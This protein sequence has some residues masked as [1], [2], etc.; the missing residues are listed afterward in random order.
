MPAQYVQL[1][2]EW[3]NS[4]T[5]SQ[6][7]VGDN[8]TKNYWVAWVC[9]EQLTD[10]EVNYPPSMKI[11]P[12]QAVTQSAMKNQPIAQRIESVVIPSQAGTF[13]LPSKSSLVQRQS[14]YDRVRYHTGEDD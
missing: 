14:T 1:S 3:Q 9:G 13:I 12:D 2:E 5:L 11:Y 6:F 4:A 7:V 8:Y 10:I